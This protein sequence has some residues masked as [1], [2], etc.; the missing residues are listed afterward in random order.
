[1]ANQKSKP[2]YPHGY[3]ARNRHKKEVRVRGSKRPGAT[4]VRHHRG[5]GLFLLPNRDGQVAVDGQQGRYVTVPYRILADLHLASPE[6]FEGCRLS[7]KLICGRGETLVEKVKIIGSTQGHIFYGVVRWYSERKSRGFIDVP[8]LER[9]VE[10]TGA[11]VR[12]SA[13]KFGVPAPEAR[14]QVQVRTVLVG[15]R[16]RAITVVPTTALAE[17]G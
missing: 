9:A 17:T 3:P 14:E 13:K 10:V 1:M 15:G 11:A 5:T 6:K 4:V 7:F 16:M 12:R 8:G 2:I